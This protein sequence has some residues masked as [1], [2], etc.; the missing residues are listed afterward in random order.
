MD[1]RQPR[2][3]WSTLAKALSLNSDFYEYARDTS[4][5]RSLALAIVLLAALSHMLGTLVILLINRASVVQLLILLFLNGLSV[6]GGYYFWSFT[7][8]KV[9][10]WLKPVDPT[11]G[12]LLVP[13]GLAYAPQVLNFL[14][15]IPLLGRPIEFLL[16]VWSLLA[17]IVAVRQGLD[18]RTR[19]A[20]LISTI[21]F[22]L[23]QAAVGSVQ[24][25]AQEWVNLN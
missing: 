9:G 2:G 12:E 1:S 17:V 5:N 11:Y 22:P 20:A 15:M 13:I 18:I 3:L 19:T 16:A 4:R 10:Q 21:G 25:L 6:V 8:L 24:V 14:T 23:V 7:I